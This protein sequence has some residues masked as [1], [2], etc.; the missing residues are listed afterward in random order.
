MKHQI[1][2]PQFLLELEGKEEEEEIKSCVGTQTMPTESDIVS[3]NN[4][5]SLKTLTENFTYLTKNQ[6]QQQQQESNFLLWLVITLVQP[7]NPFV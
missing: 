7:P 2:A 1:K 5:L 6:Q 4:S 3:D